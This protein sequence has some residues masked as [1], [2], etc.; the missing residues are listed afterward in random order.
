VAGVE[1]V[2]PTADNPQAAITPA[3][4]KAQA[5]RPQ[6]TTVVVRGKVVTM[7][8]IIESRAAV[9]LVVQATEAVRRV[10]TPH[11][12]KV[13]KRKKRRNGT[14]RTIKTISRLLRGIRTTTALR[15]ITLGATV[16][17][18]RPLRLTDDADLMPVEAALATMTLMVVEMMS[19][20]CRTWRPKTM[21]TFPISD[22]CAGIFCA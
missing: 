18:V 10:M 12:K 2:R 17:M 11:Q 13:P 22:A 5:V 16:Q 8:A 3:L 21:K 15:K 1:A 4:A 9:P 6:A 20:S 14:R 19:I 7:G